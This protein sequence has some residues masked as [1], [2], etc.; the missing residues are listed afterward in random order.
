M[1]NNKWT[2][3][4]RISS[5]SSGLARG[6]LFALGLPPPNTVN[7]RSYSERLPQGQGGQTRQGYIN[8]SILWDA[9]D[10]EQ[11]RTLN[12]IVEAGITGGIIYATVPRDDGSRLLNDFVDVSGIAH[13]LDYQ[14]ISN[15][16]GVVMQSVTLVIN[17]LT[18]TASPSSVI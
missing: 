16:M 4:W 12:R 6:H 3:Y 8:I 10:F 15:A 2:I 13:P 11:F 17:N 7:Y 9:L 1:E 14:P 5:S 18:I